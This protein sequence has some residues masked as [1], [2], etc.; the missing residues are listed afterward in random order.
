MGSARR[1]YL[2]VDTAAALERDQ[3]QVFGEYPW[4]AWL[5]GFAARFHQLGKID[6]RPFQAKSAA[7]T[8]REKERG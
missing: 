2:V 7:S 5:S 1:V 3:I 6:H 8:C 4:T